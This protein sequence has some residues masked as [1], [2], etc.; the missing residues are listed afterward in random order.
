MVAR[1][2]ELRRANWDVI[3]ARVCKRGR[4]S[5]RFLGKGRTMHSESDQSDESRKEEIPIDS[6]IME[7]RKL[8]R[9]AQELAERAGKSEQRYDRDHDIFT[10]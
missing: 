2:R 8:D 7:Q 10:K 4:H 1:G 3:K 9:L 6:R 5:G